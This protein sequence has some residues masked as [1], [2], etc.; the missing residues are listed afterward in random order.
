MERKLT[1]IFCADVVGFS[2]MMGADEEGTLQILQEC[3]AIIDPMI[4][5]AGGRIFGS[6]GDSVL[7]EFSSAVVAVK[8]AIQC[9]AALH[10]RNLENP[11]SVPMTFRMGIN[12][13]D[14]VVQGSNLFGDGVNVAARLESMADY[15]GI[16]IAG[17]VHYEVHRKLKDVV[18]V[19]RGE[20]HFKNI[21]DAV[22]IYAIE[23]PGSTLNP[24][25]EVPKPDEPAK[26]AAVIAVTAAVP[27]EAY[28]APVPV[29]PLAPIVV[30][31]IK[32]LLA[33]S[34]NAASSMSAARSHRRAGLPAKAT[35]ICLA[36]AVRKDS[37]ALEELLDLCIRH[38]I[39]K[40]SLEITAQVFV[41]FAKF[42]DHNKQNQIGDVFASGYLGAD[43]KHLSIPIW[44]MSAARN[45]DAQLKLG[46]AHM[47]NAAAT[48]SDLEEAILS[49]EKAAK[50]KN[51]KAAVRLGLFFVSDK[52]QNKELAFQWFWIAREFKDSTA[53]LNLELVIKTMT[54]AQVTSAKL[55]AETILDEISWNLGGSIE[56]DRRL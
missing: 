54:R 50:Q 55:S 25:A 23:V 39:P 27:T 36:R 6:A 31:P 5:S 34:V 13:G 17:N 15:G 30:D 8:F 10:T 41:E 56:R 53:Q 24:N 20:Q 52:N 3:R 1:T 4:V 16:S 33:D 44:R 21:E 29:A 51:A 49:L 47:D 19:D 12:I 48:E 46:F 38:H 14:V 26:M 37:E 45:S 9:Q 35:K 22:Q 40:D 32:M 7:A 43:N 42:T 18:F 28:A 11:K 2:K